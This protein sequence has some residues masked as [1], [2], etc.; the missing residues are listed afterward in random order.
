MYGNVQKSEDL[1]GTCVNG[2]ECVL[3]QNI[4]IR[5]ENTVHVIL[6]VK[7]WCVAND[8]T[9]AQQAKLL[10][11]ESGPAGQQDFWEPAPCKCNMI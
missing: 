10:S 9:Y 4:F 7:H 8:Q 1:L 2:F 3:Q 5:Y 11:V 6:I